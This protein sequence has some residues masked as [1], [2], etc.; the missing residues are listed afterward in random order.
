MMRTSRGGG[1]IPLITPTTTTRPMRK[2]SP[3]SRPGTVRCS[4]SVGRSFF[5][6]G[7][8]QFPG[9]HADAIGRRP[10]MEDACVCIGE[11]AGPRTQYYA[12]F[13]GHGGREASSYCA[14]R[15]HSLIASKYVK[16]QPLGPI[17]AKSIHEINQNVISTWEYAGTTAAIAIIADDKIYTA[18]VGDSRVILI[19]DNKATR[20]S[21]DHKATVPK[22]RRAILKRGGSIF[23]GRV[24]GMLM[25]SRAIGDATVARYISDEPF[26]TETPFKE[27]MKLIL[28]CDGVWDVMSDQNA[29]DIFLHSSQP[30][31]AARAIKNEALKR[32]SMDNVSVI[33]VDLTYKD[34]HQ[35]ISETQYQTEHHRH[36]R[37]QHK[38]H[39]DY[40]SIFND[41]SYLKQDS[42]KDK[43]QIKENEQSQENENRNDKHS[44]TEKCESSQQEEHQEEEQEE[45]KQVQQQDEQQ[46][47]EQ[48][49]QTIIEHQQD[50][51][52]VQI[53]QKQVE[54]PQKQQIIIVKQP[55]QHQ[56]Q[57]QQHQQRWQHQQQY[58]QQQY[59]QQQ[60]QQEEDE[61][62]KPHHLQIQSLHL[63]LQ[64]TKPQIV[65]TKKQQNQQ[66]IQYQQPYYKTSKVQGYQLDPRPPKI[67]IQDSQFGAT[68]TIH[69]PHRQIR[70]P[71]SK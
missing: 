69:R 62:V 5:L 70:Q 54:H 11:F 17:I 56:K 66:S 24:N 42:D 63:T 37:R 19:Y 43:E 4:R 7:K 46:D 71:D 36:S 67:P 38:Q 52:Q 15:L 49:E 55:Q 22:E 23:Q 32:G 31:D 2:I 44:D 50:Q 65:V 53:A 13:D 29:A 61:F 6:S 14:E 9:G 39:R 47:E 58:Q 8:Q 60:Q 27:G 57:Q 1:R 45:E 59:Q 30:V 33:C 20:L 68:L 18:N 25:L 3:S 41:N 64:K 51:Q 10:T 34:E 40:I 35:D 48:E 16:G 21:V 12:V 26:Q 28:A